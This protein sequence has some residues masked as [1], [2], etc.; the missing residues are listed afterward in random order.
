MAT[1]ARRKAAKTRKAPSKR[2]ARQPAIPAKFSRYYKLVLMNTPRSLAR[3]SRLVRTFTETPITAMEK[4]YLLV[5][6]WR[7]GVES[8][9]TEC[10][11]EFGVSKP[12]E[13]ALGWA[14]KAIQ[15]DPDSPY[16]YWAKAYA[17][18]YQREPAS[19]ACYYQLAAYRK[20]GFSAP[21]K[22]KHF[23]V[24]WVE[25]QV[26][27]L[28][29]S[30]LPTLIPI[31]DEHLPDNLP[32]RWIN[33]V[34]CFALH[35]MGDFSNS[36]ALYPSLPPDRD[37]SLIMAANYYRLG[38]NGQRVAHRDRFRAK[39]GNGGWT[40]DI[41]RLGSPFVDPDSN[42]FWYKSVLKGLE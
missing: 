10:V 40:A 9:M 37:T 18:K 21:R 3:A 13:C 2:R 12:L 22:W 1:A 4:A 32:E 5:V 15:L 38:N 25:S 16:G 17:Y 36:I 39:P 11:N 24:D 34:K 42:S 30:S 26:Y 33:W 20:A 6:N 35:M 8:D 7:N 19:S 41:E 27:W 31:I 29:Q 14:D 23:V 28:P